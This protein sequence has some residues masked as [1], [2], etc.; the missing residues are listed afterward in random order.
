MFSL[1]NLNF[2]F[3]SRN[4]SSD[5]SFTIILIL[6]ELPFEYSKLLLKSLQFDRLLVDLTILIKT[7][8][9]VRTD[10][11]TPERNCL[12]SRRIDP[13]SWTFFSFKRPIFFIRSS[14][15]FY[16]ADPLSSDASNYYSSPLFSV[17]VPKRDFVH[18]RDTEPRIVT[19]KG[20]HHGRL[21]WHH[22]AP[23]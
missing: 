22:T 3:M 16:R 11:I 10:H 20:P 13:A 7:H 15:V 2:L 18:H 17:R 4:I 19:T 5:N 1:D 6:T 14:I 12:R 8:H 23:H 9:R 21:Q